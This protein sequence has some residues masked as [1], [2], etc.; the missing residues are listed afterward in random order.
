M[1]N[2]NKKANNESD[3]QPEIVDETV[4]TEVEEVD[5]PD[6]VPLE[7]D[8]DDTA[9]LKSEIASLN[10]KLLRMRA[11]YDNYRKRVFKDLENSRSAAQIDTLMP[12][13]QVFDHFSM[14]MK[15]VE[16]SDNI[17]ALKQGL[18]MI[19]T[20]YQRAFD[21]IG[22]QKLD[23]T[24]Q[25]FDP[26]LHEAMANEASEEVPEG[27]VIKQW[28]FGYKLGERLLRPARVVVSSGPEEK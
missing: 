12:F 5:Q 27:T 7:T 23:A 26:N 22:I 11:E 20:E 25:P 18:N 4:F 19:L 24:G 17:E 15:S 16:M 2:E 28:S 3:K 14:A 10:D 9:A 21:D 6:D 1:N 8:L 13:L